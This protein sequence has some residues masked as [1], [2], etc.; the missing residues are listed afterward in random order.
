MEATGETSMAGNKG[1]A[2]T[3]TSCRGNKYR[4]QQ[5]GATISANKKTTP[6]ANTWSNSI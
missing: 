6:H 5:Q 3:C 2:A 4:E 1:H